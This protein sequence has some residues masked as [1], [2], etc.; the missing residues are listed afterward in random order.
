MKLEGVMFRVV[1]FDRFVSCVTQ[2]KGSVPSPICDRPPHAFYGFAVCFHISAV[3]DH[4][5]LRTWCS[6]FK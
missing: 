3:L 1:I 2:G 4:A 5:T 6:G